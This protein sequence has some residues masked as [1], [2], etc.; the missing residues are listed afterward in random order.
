MIINVESIMKVIMA[1]L[2]LTNIMEFKNQAIAAER[3]Q[4]NDVFCAIIYGE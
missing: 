2:Y 1:N 3:W 4:N